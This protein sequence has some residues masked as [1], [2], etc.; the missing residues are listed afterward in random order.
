MV[1]L[2]LLELERAVKAKGVE[3]MI[4]TYDYVIDNSNM[5]SNVRVALL[6]GYQVSVASSTGAAWSTIQS[7]AATSMTRSG[8][9]KPLR[10]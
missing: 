3:A 4:D 2:K 7:C 9:W 1:P 8:I 10:R 5:C 6:N